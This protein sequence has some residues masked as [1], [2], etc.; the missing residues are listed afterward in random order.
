MEIKQNI[1]PHLQS[2][3]AEIDKQIFYHEATLANLKSTR[4]AFIE[5]QPHPQ[6]MMKINFPLTRD[7]VRNLMR[8]YGQPMQTVQIIDILYKGITEEERT[9]NIKTLSVILNQ[10]EKANEITSERKAGVKGNFYKWK[11]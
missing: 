6:K 2:I 1:P 3:I 7:L 8:G 5:K 10:M 11:K 4:K 9:K